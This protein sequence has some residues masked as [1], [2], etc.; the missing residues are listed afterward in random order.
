VEGRYISF[1]LFSTVG[2]P[3]SGGWKYYE[4]L[5]KCVDLSAVND[6]PH[7]ITKR[8]E[9]PFVRMWTIKKKERKDYCAVKTPCMWN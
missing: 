5:K 4:A 9:L 7:R 1:V 8:V 6:E 3:L 2:L